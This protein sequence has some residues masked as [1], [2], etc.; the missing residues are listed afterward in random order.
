MNQRAQELHLGPLRGGHRA[1]HR[2]DGVLVRCCRAFCAECWQREFGAGKRGRPARRLPRA[3]SRCVQTGARTVASVS[4]WLRVRRIAALAFIALTAMVSY[5]YVTAMMQPSSLPLWPRTVEWVRVH[6]GNWL[7]DKTEHYYSSW[8]APSKGGPQL[9]TLAAVGL[10]PQAKRTQ[11][12]VPAVHREPSLAR[13]AS[14]PCSRTRCRMRL[15]GSGQACSC[16][17]GH[18]CS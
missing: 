13:R 9:T 6:H 16:A 5:S 17:A 14:S 15:C 12:A 7:V 1:G 2:R 11:A 3:R 10:G 18:R 8:K 4:R